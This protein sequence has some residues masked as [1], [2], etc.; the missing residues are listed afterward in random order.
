MKTQ[1]YRSAAD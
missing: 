1:V